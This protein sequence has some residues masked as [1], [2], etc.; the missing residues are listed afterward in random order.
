VLAVPRL[1]SRGSVNGA[2]CGGG[3][4]WIHTSR[5]RIEPAPSRAGHPAAGP[6]LQASPRTPAPPPLPP[7]TPALHPPLPAPPGPAVPPPPHRWPPPPRAAARTPPPVPS[8]GTITGLL[9]AGGSTQRPSRGVTVRHC[10]T[11]TCQSRRMHL[12]WEKLPW[13]SGTRRDGRTNAPPYSASYPV[14][15]GR[16]NS[17]AGQGRLASNPLTIPPI[18]PF[19][20]FQ[21]RYHLAN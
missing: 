10:D 2:P 5:L 1:S 17:T 14:N 20:K 15:T 9:A 19:D 21:V 18:N 11:K 13:C 8:G 4:R 7:A 6:A 3:L 12:P 16:G